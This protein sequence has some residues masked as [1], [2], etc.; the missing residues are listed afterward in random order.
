MAW[1]RS[2]ADLRAFSS[3]RISGLQSTDR[4]V[5]DDGWVTIAARHAAAPSSRVIV[6]KDGCRLTWPRLSGYADPN[7]AR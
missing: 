6:L 5:L 2:A 1:S 7:V 3:A 4:Q